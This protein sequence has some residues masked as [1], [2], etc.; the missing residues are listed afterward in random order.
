MIIEL[1]DAEAHV[2]EMWASVADGE[3]YVDEEGEE[4][5]EKLRAVDGWPSHA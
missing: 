5:L 4:L 2:I 3:S 1:T